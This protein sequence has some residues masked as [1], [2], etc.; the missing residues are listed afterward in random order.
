MAGMLRGSDDAHKFSSIDD[1]KK[2]QR[3][4]GAA[5]Y[6]FRPVKFQ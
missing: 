6:C 1:A 2:A 4:A 3:A 5:R